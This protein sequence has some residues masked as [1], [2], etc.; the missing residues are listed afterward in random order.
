VRALKVQI[1]LLREKLADRHQ[2]FRYIHTV[3]EEGYLFE[4]RK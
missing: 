4:P 3:R 1:S 2:P